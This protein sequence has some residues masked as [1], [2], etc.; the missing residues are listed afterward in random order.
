M[1][2][3]IS[4]VGGKKLLRKEIINRF[5][6][7]TFDRYIEVFGG[8]AWVLFGKDRH[9]NM[10]VYNDANSE[11]V[12]LFRCVKYH[13]EEL[14]R[15]L[16]G[17]LNSRELFDDIRLQKA[18][19]GLTDIQRAARFYLII[20]MSY[21]SDARSFSCSA[22][23]LEPTIEY[24]TAIKQRLSNVVIECKDFENLI[25]VYDRPTAL[26]Y[27]DPP[28]HGTESHYIER[29]IEADHVRLRDVL[30]HAQGRFILS[31]NDDEYI[32][33][34]YAGYGIDEVTRPYG[35]SHKDDKQ[36]KI[37][38]ELIIRNY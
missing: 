26:F 9:A 31:Y 3:F 14:Q 22:T 4:W 17:Y 29:F 21:G 28:Y 34:L 36:K 38:K 5:P 15:E 13:C 37:C 11:L 16:G 12:N 6:T 8:A 19:R 23:R 33:S 2:S 10:E 25:Q 27:C 35:L 1:N 24:L 7:D 18:T 30:S 20:K 32:R